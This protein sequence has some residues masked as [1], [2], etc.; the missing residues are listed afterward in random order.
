MVPKARNVLTEILDCDLDD[1]EK[2]ARSWGTRR[3]GS[4]ESIGASRG[5]GKRS[6]LS[7]REARALLDRC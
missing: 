4:W 1:D 5:L 6:G 3:A 7:I 2:A